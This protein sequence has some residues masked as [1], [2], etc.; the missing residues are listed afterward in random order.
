[1]NPLVQLTL[2]RLREFLREPAAIFWTFGFPILLAF[3]LG[4]AFRQGPPQRIPVA[5]LSGPAQEPRL[6]LLQGDG[7]FHASPASPEELPELFRKGEA[8]LAV[9]G[10]EALEYRFDPAHAEA[11]AARRDVDDLL[12]RAAGRRDALSVEDLPVETPGSLYIE[13]LVPGLLGFNIM[14]SSLWGIGWHIVQ[15]RKRRL[16]KR[17]VATPMRRSHYLLSHILSRLAFLAAEA[18]ALLAF[19]ALVFQ[20]EVR[21]GLVAFSLFTLLGAMTFAGFGLLVASRTEN[22]ETVSGLVNLLVFPQMLL[23]GVFFSWA[24]FPEWL[25]PL[26]RALPLTLFNDGLRGLLGGAPA[27]DLLLPALALA[28]YGVTSFALALRLFRWL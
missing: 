8:V 28:A 14:S 13:F 21:G 18:V 19:A 9:G 16:L 3:V 27:G 5:V 26:C 15:T 1:M 20:V 24:H 10:G 25:Q 12:Q 22:V 2:A 7:R 6:D 11:V 23:S 4:L 17:L